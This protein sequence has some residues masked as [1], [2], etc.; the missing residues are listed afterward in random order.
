VSGEAQCKLK[1]KI[2]T[3]FS[4]IGRS[5]VTFDQQSDGKTV[6]TM[7]QLHPTKE[8]REAV[9][10]FGGVEYGYQTLGKLAKHVESIK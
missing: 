8:Q 5:T 10:G 7:R 3:Q 6:I 9:I 1:I 2:K 4:L